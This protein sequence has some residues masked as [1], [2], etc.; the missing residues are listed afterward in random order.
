MRS[1]LRDEFDL[2]SIFEKRPFSDDRIAKEKAFH[3]S[4]ASLLPGL[5]VDIGAVHPMRWLQVLRDCNS[6]LK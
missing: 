2:D 4:M 1:S 6:A 3:F 5:I